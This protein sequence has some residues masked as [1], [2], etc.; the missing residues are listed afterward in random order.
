[1]R[2]LVHLL[3]RPRL[4][5]ADRRVLHMRSHPVVIGGN[6]HL[7]GGL[8]NSLVGRVHAMVTLIIGPGFQAKTFQ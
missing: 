6:L 7:R 5:L 8:W 4:Q 2:L 3:G 1:M